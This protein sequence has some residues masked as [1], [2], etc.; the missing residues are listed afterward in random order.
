MAPWESTENQRENSSNTAVGPAP[1]RSCTSSFRMLAARCTAACSRSEVS[2]LLQSSMA[3]AASDS[4]PATPR[5]RSRRCGGFLAADGAIYA[6]HKLTAATW[7]RPGASSRAS[8]RLAAGGVRRGLV[9]A[10][11]AW[12]SRLQLI[13][14]CRAPGSAFT[15]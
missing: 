5:R 7:N 3:R 12:G 14:T 1:T 2:R 10:V 6:S 9:G 8:R 4:G 11:W 15:T 13:R